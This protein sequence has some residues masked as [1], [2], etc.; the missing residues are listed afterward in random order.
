MLKTNEGEI[1]VKVAVIG[2]GSMGKRR[3]GIVKELMPDCC[4]CGVDSR[5][6]RRAE[7]V[8]NIG[9]ECFSS[10]ESLPDDVDCALVHIASFT[11][12]RYYR[13]LA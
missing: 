12:R 2:L 7:A 4:V 8:S 11:C 13:V 6:D 5:E 3:I 9:I 10:I 1:K